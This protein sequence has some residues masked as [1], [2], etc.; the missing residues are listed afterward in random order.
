MAA[1][2]R[3]DDVTPPTSTPE[4]GGSS[5]SIGRKV[6]GD[7]NF[8]VSALPIAS[9]PTTRSAG[10]KSQRASRKAQTY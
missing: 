10:L 7:P 6:G 3:I 9:K 8:R 4:F 5:P 1:G 2:Q